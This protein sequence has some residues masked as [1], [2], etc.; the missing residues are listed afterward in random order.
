MLGITIGY[1]YNAQCIYL[2]VVVVVVSGTT[3]MRYTIVYIFGC[4][5]PVLWVFDGA[6][7]LS[8]RSL[9]MYSIINICTVYYIN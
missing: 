2:R 7:G 3:Y 1:T 4:D 8:R 9:F 6:T 5:T